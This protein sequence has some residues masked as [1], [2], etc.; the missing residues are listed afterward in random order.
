MPSTREKHKGLIRILLEFLIPL[1][2]HW[3]TFTFTNWFSLSFYG[4]MV[5]TFE[6]YIHTCA[7]L[8]CK[9]TDILMI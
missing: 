8:S 6:Q 2:N 9:S 4:C 5:A 7:P 1:V 3:P